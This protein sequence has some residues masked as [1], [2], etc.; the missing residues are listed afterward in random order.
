VPPS[1]VRANVAQPLNV[2]A[3]LLARLALDAHASQ[4][5]G[6]VEQLLLLERA[7]RRRRVDKVAGHDLGA[8]LRADAVEGRQGALFILAVV[9]ESPGGLLG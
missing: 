2:L 8:H 4:L 6:E 5:R 1:P 7:D 3:H 9:S